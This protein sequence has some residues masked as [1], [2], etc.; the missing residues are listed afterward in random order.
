[1]RVLGIDPGKY[2]ALVLIEGN[3]IL[4]HLTMP[5]KDDK[6]DIEKLDWKIGGV[7]SLTD[8]AYLEKVDGWKGKGSQGMF[9]FGRTV[10]LIE[11][12]LVAHGIPYKQVL[13]Q[14]WQAAMFAGA[15]G[16]GKE[17][18]QFF[19]E[20]KWPAIEF[21]NLKKIEKEGIWDAACIADYGRRCEN[22]LCSS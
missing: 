12:G 1:M 20:N 17:R 5:L 8:I 9:S 7:K 16:K 18:S 6:I 4:A 14:T 3:D 10:G 11:M 15:L 2:G 13:P 22:I 21:K 19:F